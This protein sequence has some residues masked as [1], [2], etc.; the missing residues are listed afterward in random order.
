MHGTES[1]NWI[2][3]FIDTQNYLCT[4]K[5]S[6]LQTYKCSALQT[7]KCSALQK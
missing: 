7:Y 4:Y 1:I 3:L 2:N 5:W 6:A